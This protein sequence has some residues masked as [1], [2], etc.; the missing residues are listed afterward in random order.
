MLSEIKTTRFFF[1][2]FI[3]VLVKMYFQFVLM[4]WLRFR[5]KIWTDERV[6]L[7]VL[8]QTSDDLWASESNQFVLESIR[9]SG[10]WEITLMDETH[11]QPKDTN[12]SPKILFHCLSSCHWAAAFSC[13]ARGNVGGRVLCDDSSA[14]STFT[15]TP[16]PHDVSYV[17]VFKLLD[18][19]LSNWI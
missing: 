5:Y 6:V 14:A 15:L 1:S 2:E 16:T 9:T 12:S 8:C 17:T 7:V 18:Q 19:N 13:V 4:F 3:K 10:P 11:E